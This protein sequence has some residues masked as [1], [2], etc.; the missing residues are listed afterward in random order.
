MTIRRLKL[1][2]R[3]SRNGIIRVCGF[4]PEAIVLMGM[5]ERVW[6]VNGTLQV[7]LN[8]ATGRLHVM[9]PRDSGVTLSE[10]LQGRYVII[11]GM[12]FLVWCSGGWDF[13]ARVS[14][15]VESADEVAYHTIESCHALLALQR[16]RDELDIEDTTVN[17]IAAE[18][19]E[20]VR[21]STASSSRGP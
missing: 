16:R 7:M 12:S 19:V 3:S 4:T 17:V 13:K 21:H 11:V 15:M 10:P 5:V 8:D 2:Q 9:F 20:R 14:R 18:A 6:W 1:A